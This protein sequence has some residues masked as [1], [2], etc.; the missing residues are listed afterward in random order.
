MWNGDV[1]PVTRYSA[2]AEIVMLT[3]EQ[4][5]NNIDAISAREVLERFVPHL[6]PAPTA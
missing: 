3:A 4:A 6:P 2:Y 5:S 1:I